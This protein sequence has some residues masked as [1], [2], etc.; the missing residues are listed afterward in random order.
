MGTDLSLGRRSDDSDSIEV[1]TGTFSDEDVELLDLFV[2]NMSR[3]LGSRASQ[4]GLPVISRIAW[5]E[6]RGLSF[7]CEVVDDSAL[8]E[9]LHVLRPLILQNERASFHQISALIVRRFAD[10]ELGQTM[11]ELRQCFERGQ[12]SAYM[13]VSIGEQSLF[14]DELFKTWLNGELYHSDKE[15]ARVWRELEVSLSASNTR[16][17]VINQLN[18]KVVA[19]CDLLNLIHMAL[20]SRSAE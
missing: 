14:D 7:T 17:L 2:S 20:G 15:K 8:Y 6:S 16:A 5:D 18:G 1:L 12:L 11:K 10:K 13:N 3:V 9:L 4:S 19:L